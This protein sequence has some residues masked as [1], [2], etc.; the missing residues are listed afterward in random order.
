MPGLFDILEDVAA[1]PAVDS[2]VEKLVGGL[3]SHLKELLSQGSAAAIDQVLNDGIENT[4][5][6]VAA[7]T[8]NTPNAPDTASTTPAPEPEQEPQ[9]QTEEEQQGEDS[10]PGGQAA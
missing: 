10:P 6:I 2:S 5:K 4:G 3:F 7:V 8:A 1:D 9:P